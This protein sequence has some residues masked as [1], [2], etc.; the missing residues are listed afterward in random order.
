MKK[1]ERLRK[2]VYRSRIS[3]KKEGINLIPK[4]KTQQFMKTNFSEIKTPEIQKI[5][6]QL[7]KYN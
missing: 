7:L 2:Q 4:S 5:S 1:V 6:R 3:S